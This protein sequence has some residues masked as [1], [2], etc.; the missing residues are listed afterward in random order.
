MATRTYGLSGSGIDVDQM[1]KGLMKAQRSRYDNMVQKKT[2]LEWKKA[3]YNTMYNAISN[4]RNS[5]FNYKLQST[6]APK[7]ATS[8]NDAA[9][10][11]SANAD[12]AN[13]SHS[14]TVHQLAEGVKVTSSGSITDT[15]S[16]KTKDTLQTQFGLTG[17]FDIVLNDGTNTPKTINVDSSKSIYDLVGNINNSGL[18][19]KANYD[20]T[21]DRFFIY[22]T[23][24]GSSTKL[25]LSA[26]TGTGK[27]F[28]EDNLKLG[29]VAT[30]VSG[31]DAI[32][33]LD[34]VGSTT[35][36]GDATNLTMSN[37]SF[38]ISG[39]TYNL[40]ATGTYAVAVS[41]DNDKAVAS[42]KSFIESYNTVLGKIN[43]ELSETK[44]KDYLPLTD[45][46]KT[47]MKDTDITAWETKAKSGTLR[48]DPILQDL[49]NNMRSSISSPIAGVTGKYNSLSSIGITT[50]DYSEGG[51][52]YLDE[53]KF[54]T[55]LEADPDI[56]NKLFAASGDD[57]SK[58]GAAVRLYDTLK[59]SMDKIVGQA[60]ITASTDYDNKSVLAKSILD[61]DKQMSDL[62]TKLS[63][64]EDRYYKQF[65][66]MEA[67]L[68]KMTQ[69]SSWLSQ[70]LG[71]SK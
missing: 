64:M 53:K 6:L 13:I 71:S 59:I 49:V 1:V 8:S 46:Q 65:D 12:A 51:K 17:T 67:A 10:T 35:I 29:S 70:Q 40:K 61:Y 41:S 36:P 48:S 45:D 68:N 23:K 11:V 58:E 39:V 32:F 3:D 25:D 57:S 18:N 22:T 7:Q 27:T 24:T 2:Q 14:I 54:K 69:Q 19:I 16:G 60:G 30:V 28:L 56:V 15:A 63:D 26:T 47:S 4:F 37:N 42:V 52:L 31:K 55:A 34:G 20:A 43:G 5:V 62:N 66:A 50:G 33:A 9:I 44:Y 38:T 21:L